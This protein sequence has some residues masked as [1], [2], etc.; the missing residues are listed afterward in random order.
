MAIN[1]PQHQG[2]LTPQIEALVNDFI[3]EL[4]A[5]G[6]EYTPEDYLSALSCP[7]AKAPITVIT[8][9]GLTFFGEYTHADKKIQ[10]FIRANFQQMHG[11]LHTTIQQL[12]SAIFI[13][14][15]VAE[16]GIIPKGKQWVLDRIKILTPGRWTFR[17]AKGEIT[18]IRYYSTT[19]IDVPYEQVLHIVN[20]PHIAFD[21]PRGVSDLDGA[22]ASIKAWH[23]LMSEMIIAGQR[24]ATPLT[25]GYYDGEVAD[26]L[27]Y[28]ANGNPILDELGNQRTKTP[29]DEMSEQLSNL[30]NKTVLVTSVK[31][32]IEAIANNADVQFFE[33]ALNICQK[34]IF[35]SFLFPETALQVAGGGGDS[36]L[37]TGHMSLLETNVKALVDQIKETMLDKMIR[38]LI[39]WNFGDRDDWGGFE[40]PSGQEEKRV[41]LGTLLIGAFSNQI[42]TIDDLEAVNKLREF[43]G[44]SKLDKL[45]D[46]PTPPPET[47]PQELSTGQG[48]SLGTEYWRMFE[49]NGAT[50]K[51]T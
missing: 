9:M 27:L 5:T 26:T 20:N 28:D 48:F 21:D 6:K 36:N 23:I 18:D 25:A 43:V 10:D 33:Q 37:N 11:S 34:A 40:V 22:I 2:T 4:S 42:F 41:E 13:G 17:G 32:R 8:L 47:A 31:N 51:S 35:M 14:H 39:V 38:P 3:Q 44:I 19:N 50:A 15:S 29:G 49:E 30:E 24:K 1:K 12:M 45:P 16:W 7:I 46:A